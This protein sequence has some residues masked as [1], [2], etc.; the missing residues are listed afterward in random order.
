M[1]TPCGAAL[2]SAAL[3]FAAHPPMLQAPPPERS[4]ARRWGV[5]STEKSA[6]IHLSGTELEEWRAAHASKPA[7]AEQERDPKKTLTTVPMPSMV[8]DIVN[9][10]MASFLAMDRSVQPRAAAQVSP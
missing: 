3:S 5:Y 4:T 2:C 1:L 7:V 10:G 9:V 6:K 8:T